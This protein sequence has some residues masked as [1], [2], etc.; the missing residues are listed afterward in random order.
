MG[1]LGM[2]VM[3]S[4]FSGS[5]PM[6]FAKKLD[7][8]LS[9]VCCLQEDNV[10]QL[11]P[12]TINM[13]KSLMKLI[14]VGEPVKAH[15][16]GA[17]GPRDYFA[18]RIGDVL[19]REGREYDSVSAFSSDMAFLHWGDGKQHTPHG[20]TVCYVMR[21]GVWVTLQSLGFAAAAAAAAAAP[22]VA[23]LP[24]GTAAPAPAPAPAP[25]APEAPAPEAAL[26]L[27]LAASEDRCAAAL[28]CIEDERAAH[29]A[30]DARLLALEAEI[31]SFRA[32]AAALPLPPPPAAVV[33]VEVLN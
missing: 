33:E 22:P 20:A 3:F 23:A 24:T 7:E 10:R 31:A 30:K 25:A 12:Y 9:R 1:V 16:A 17:P 18:T 21:G 6:I 27:L 29:A 8:C 13:C 14:H 5:F 26:R 11:S 19:S 15:L 4:V 28:M 32:W 2:A